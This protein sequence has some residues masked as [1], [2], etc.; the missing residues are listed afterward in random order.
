LA[1]K[2]IDFERIKVTLLNQSP[3]EL[4]KFIRSTKSQDEA[5]FLFWAL[6]YLDQ[7]QKE[8]PEKSK[9]ILQY[10]LAN[11]RIE[12]KSGEFR[13]LIVKMKNTNLNPLSN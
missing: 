12:A 13:P 10:H 4:S 11:I 9:Q 2:K 1:Q 5:M 8:I 3:Q 6:D 7:H